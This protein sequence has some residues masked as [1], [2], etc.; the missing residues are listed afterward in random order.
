MNFFRIS[1]LSLVNTLIKSIFVVFCAIGVNSVYAVSIDDLLSDSKISTV[2]ISPNGKILSFRFLQDGIHGIGFLDRKSNQIIGRKALQNGHAVGNYVWANNERVVFEVMHTSKTRKVPAFL[3]ELF[4]HNIDGSQSRLIYGYRAFAKTVGRSSNK[5]RERSWGRIIDTL[6]KDKKHILI[7]TQPWSQSGGKPAATALLNIYNGKLKKTKGVRSKHAFPSF[8]TDDAGRVRLVSSYTEDRNVHLQTLPKKGADWLEMPTEKFTDEFLAIA[9]SSTAESAYVLDVMDRDRLGLY[10]LALDGSAFK[11]LYTNKKV[12]IT[13]LSLSTT[14]HTVYA[15]RIDAGVPSYTL[16][17]KSDEAKVFKQLLGSFPG[18]LVTITSKS[19]DG[20]YWVAVVHSDV[21]PG[22]YYLFDKNKLEVRHLFNSKPELNSSDLAPTDAIEFT[23][24]D[25]QAV[26]GYLTK[27]KTSQAQMKKAPPMVVYVHGGPRARDYWGFDP[28]IQ[29]LATRGYSVLQI[30]FRGSIGYGVKFRDAGNLHW[31]D[32]VQQ[33]IISGTK[34]AIENQL[35]EAGNICIMGASFGAY[36]ALQSSILEP[37]L[38]NC[39]IANAGIYD[40]SLLYTEGDV[41]NNFS[42][43]SYL[44]EA[45]GKDEA[46]LAKFSP[47][48]SVEKL[49]APVFIAHGKEDVR[50]PF[51]HAERLREALQKHNKPHEWFVKSNEGHGFY[52]GENRAQYLNAILGFLDKNTH[53]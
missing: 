48:H 28:T 26:S 22:T 50:A 1:H 29:A 14:G 24:F 27:A 39:A 19:K 3:G 43:L 37:D 23:S 30:N 31:G 25:G 10:R 16:F 20:R 53:Q 34:W 42:G 41:E 8:L 7:S 45:I 35:A 12:D 44:E 11:H 38:Y 52:Q 4:G 49:K 47:V 21:N 18:N 15:A 46:L 32:D 5:A 13:Q 2:K 17:S 33:D 40:L 9:L 6:E 36:S 51:I